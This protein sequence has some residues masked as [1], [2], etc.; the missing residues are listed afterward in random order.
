MY[1]YVYIHGLTRVA[2]LLLSGRVPVA[3]LGHNTHTHTHTHTH[4]YIYIYISIYIYIYMHLCTCTHT[5]V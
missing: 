5:R 3:Q 4:I 1:V 2:H